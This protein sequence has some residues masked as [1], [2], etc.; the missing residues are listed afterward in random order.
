MNTLSTH[1]SL[2]PVQWVA[3]IAVTL[4]ALT[5]IAAM[6]GMLPTFKKSE[7]SAPLV[8][9]PAVT[10]AVPVTPAAA[11]TPVAAAPAQKV[12]VKHVIVNEKPR[13][14]ERTIQTTRTTQTAQ[15]APEPMPAPAPA[16]CHDCGYIESVQRIEQQGVG[17]GLGTVAGGVIGGALG[18]RVGQGSGRT[19][20]TVVGL[21][22]GAMVG[23]NIEKSRNQ[24]ASWQTVVRF[25]DGTSRVFTNDVEPTWRDGERVRLVNGS[26]QPDYAY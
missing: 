22:G 7:A 8:V 1:S 21:I 2:H 18:N 16:I 6:T 26:L 24:V 20:A 19:V 25:E 5:G 9:E 3:A 13:V 23:N 12:I 11:P 14:V 17:S 15:A 4:A 10:A